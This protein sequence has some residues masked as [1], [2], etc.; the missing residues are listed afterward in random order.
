MLIIA[1]RSC[2]NTN[3]ANFTYFPENPLAFST[4]YFCRTA[5]RTSSYSLYAIYVTQA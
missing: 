4:A 2:K 3:N 1:G 5:E